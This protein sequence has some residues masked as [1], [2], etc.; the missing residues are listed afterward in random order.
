LVAVNLYGL[1]ESQQKRGIIILKKL[2]KDIGDEVKQFVTGKTIDAVFPPILYIIGNSIFGL[3]IGII[4]AISVA[5][6][7]SIFRAIKKQSILYALGGIGGVIIASGFALLSDNAANYFLPK[8]ITSGL[9]FLVSLVSILSGRPL[10]ALLSHLA[11]GWEFDWFQRKDIK[12]AY[13]E[14]TIAWAILFLF[15]MTIQFIIFKEGNL[16]K[17]G[18]ANILLGFPTT[19]GVLILTLI[20]GIWRLKNLGG[21]GIDEFRE[22]KE[23]PWIGQRKGF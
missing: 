14:V 12:P 10:A 23:P 3:K 5:I 20:Y 15:R 22:G 17:L 9:L 16:V 13:T 11:R 2:L 1:F 8:V 19:L 4:L 6:L 7:M 18:W 21:P